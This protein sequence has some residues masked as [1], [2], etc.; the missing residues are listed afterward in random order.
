MR[1]LRILLLILLALFDVVP[2]TTSA[3]TI[4]GT[5]PFTLQNGTIADANQVMSDLNAIVAGVNANAANAGANS[6]IT[7]LNGLTTPLSFTAGGSSIYIGGLSSG[8]A[9]AYVVASPIPTGFTLVTGK[10]ISFVANFSNTGPTQL[11][12]AGTGPTNFFRQTTSGPVAMVGGEVV[13]NQEV[14]A[15]F[16]GTQFQCLN[17]A[18]AALVPTGTVVDFV[19]EIIPSG[20]L[21]ANGTAVSRTTFSILFNTISVTSVSA[22]T[23]SG[24]PTIAV[25]NSALFQLGWF[26][27]GPNVPCNSTIQNI[28]TGSSITISANAGASGAT[29]L[30]IGPYPQGDCSTTFNLPNFTGRMTAGVDGT[31]NITSATCTN[32]GSLGANC[33]AQTQTLTLPQLP[34]GITVSGS[35]TISVSTSPTNV[36][37]GGSIQTAFQGGGSSYTVVESPATVGVITST[38][39]NT[40]T[41]T[42]NNTNGVAHPILP[43]VSMVFKIIKT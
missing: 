32:A 10:V 5:L 11:N 15:Q 37:Q 39:T 12:V 42:S 2:A 33:G 8:S 38:G 7:A 29:T 4:I 13:L 6:N 17:C 41:A 19:S 27:G 43:P 21:L 24:N 3:Q 36:S 34:T 22:T 14:W 25:S 9:N 16:D 30:T 1:K 20:W 35:N 18:Q 23:T 26:V 31:T 28:P 40:I